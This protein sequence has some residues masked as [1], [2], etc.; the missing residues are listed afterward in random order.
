MD[1]FDRHE[2]WLKTVLV[3]FQ[4]RMLNHRDGA[5]QQLNAECVASE[6][7]VYADALL[8]EI[9]EVDETPTQAQ[10]DRAALLAVVQDFVEQCDT[11]GDL[12]VGNATKEQR[13][14]V[15]SLMDLNPRTIESDD[16]E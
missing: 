7:V 6:S 14:R 4:A 16:T 8:K 2:F 13:Q 12:P 1:E 15:H 5:I 3:A 9:E 11:M 10:I